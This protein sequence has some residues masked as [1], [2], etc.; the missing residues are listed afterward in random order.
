[1]LYL[2]SKRN[3]SSRVVVIVCPTTITEDGDK[4][5]F[6]INSYDLTTFAI[7][8]SSIDSRDAFSS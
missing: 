6:N 2:G 5:P 4:I 8:G 1:V 7:K 3:L